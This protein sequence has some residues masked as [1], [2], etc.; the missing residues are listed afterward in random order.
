MEYSVIQRINELIEQRQENVSKFAATLEIPQTTLNNY[1][2]GQRKPTFGLIDSILTH[3][4]EVSAEWLLRGV[5][6]MYNDSVAASKDVEIAKLEA[7]VEA[8]KDVIVRMSEPQPQQR[9]SV[10]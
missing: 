2:L 4:P 1:M 7:Q 10:G 9:K 5:G 3:L 6:R 8:L